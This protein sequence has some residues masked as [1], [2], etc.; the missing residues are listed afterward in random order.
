MQATAIA[1][2]NIA[3]VKYWGKRD[4]ALNLPAAGS[5][6]MTL[7]GLETRTTVE[8][9]EGDVDHVRINGVD[10]SGKELAKTSR[11]LDL[12]RP[13]ALS[14][15][16]D[17]SNSFPTS[18]GLASS[19]SGFAALALAATKAAGLDLSSQAL[20]VLARRGSGSAARSIVGGFAIWHEGCREDGTDSFAE[21]LAPQTHWD[22]HCLALVTVKGP[23]DVPSTEGMNLTMR[24]SPYYKAWIQTVNQDLELAKDAILGRDFEALGEVAEGSCLAMHASA[25]AARPGVIYWSART[26]ELV[27]EVRSLRASGT[28]CFFTIDAGPHVKVFCPAEVAPKVRAHFQ[29]HPAVVDILEARP[30]AGTELL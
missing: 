29:N 5:I 22:L 4:A 20:S 13:G 25:M 28:P 24:T 11:F 9:R 7:D 3:L 10:L 2:S 1:R 21:E 12:V 19:A 27:H 14:A 23:K 6:S 17:S 8:F 18:A 16:V 26:L 30:G 15:V